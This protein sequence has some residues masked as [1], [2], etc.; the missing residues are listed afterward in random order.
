MI[1]KELLNTL[2][3]EFGGRRLAPGEPGRPVKGLA[4]DEDAE[5]WLCPDEIVVTGR[6]KLDP[7]SS[8]PL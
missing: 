4:L 7:G 3:E 5:N 8:P 6:E 2:M 1:L